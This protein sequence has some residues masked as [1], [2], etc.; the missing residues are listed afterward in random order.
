[1]TSTAANTQFEDLIGLREASEVTNLQTRTISAYVAT[2][3]IP[4]LRIADRRLF[5]RSALMDWTEQR[6]L[7]REA[8]RQTQSTQTSDAAAA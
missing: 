6:R 2:G 5:S 8:A 4:S 3:R 7:R 1:M